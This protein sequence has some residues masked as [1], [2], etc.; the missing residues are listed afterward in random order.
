MDE[1][2][3]EFQKEKAKA[4]V[5]LDGRTIGTDQHRVPGDIFKFMNELIR[6]EIKRTDD[7]MTKEILKQKEEQIKDES[8]KEEWQAVVAASNPATLAAKGMDDLTKFRKNKEK[9]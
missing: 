5:T 8:V 6:H 3:S 2:K 7:R 1:A 4:F 9:R